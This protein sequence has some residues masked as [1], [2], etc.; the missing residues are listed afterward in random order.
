M[1]EPGPARNPNMR[2]EA[3]VAALLEP[4]ARRGAGAGAGLMQTV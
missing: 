3:L 4:V 2:V 1:R